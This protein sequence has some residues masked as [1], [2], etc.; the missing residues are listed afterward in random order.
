[1]TTSTVSLNKQRCLR[2]K[3]RRSQ[4]IW[5][6]APELSPDLNSNKVNDRRI[7]ILDVAPDQHQPF[8]SAARIIEQLIRLAPLSYKKQLAEVRSAMNVLVASHLRTSNIAQLAALRRVS[9]ESI[10]TALIIDKVTREINEVLRVI[11]GGRTIVVPAADRLDRSTL[12]ILARSM[13]LLQE[14]DPLTWEWRLKSVPEEFSRVDN[15]HAPQ[16]LWTATRT[17]FMTKLQALLDPQIQTIGSGSVDYDHEQMKSSHHSLADISA[18]LVLQ[19]YDSCFLWASQHPDIETVSG[20]SVDLWRAVAIAAVNTGH[21]RSALEFL[22]RAYL[23]A[24]TATLRAHTSYL[25]GLIVA[26][27]VYSI[28]ESNKLYERGIRELESITHDD[29][30]DPELEE[31]WILNGFALNN[32]LSVRLKGHD[33]A[34]VSK[35]TFSLLQQAFDL[36]R[37]GGSPGRVYLRFNLLR[38]MSHFLEIQQHYDFALKTWQ[39]TFKDLIEEVSGHEHVGRATINYRLG[40]LHY[41]A[42]RF[43]EAARFLNT[44]LESIK[45]VG[46][47]FRTLHI[48]RA[49][50]TVALARKQFDEASEAFTRGIKLGL[51]HRILL[52]SRYHLQSLALTHVS[53]GCKAK[54]YEVLDWMR[55][56]EPEIFE[57]KEVEQKTTL[58]LWKLPKLNSSLPNSVPEIDLEDT[59]FLP[60]GKVL[61]GVVSV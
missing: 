1:M 35:K 44:A 37:E 49:I 7:L 18:A 41:K 48:L 42:N 9:R 15:T 51:K 33:V 55:A 25:Q 20:D 47:D 12:K 56:E 19:N 43:S 6:I 13:L 31:A 38:N 3:L 54:A 24:P 11:A 17:N 23:E 8:A 46:C 58:G 34:I 40:Y 29:P 16:G 10:D 36:V 50:G 60:V 5:S 59:P 21:Y 4:R 2:P 39:E 32:L 61:T 57:D 53:A 22:E 30:G 26:K 52:D 14:S 28:E 45:V 27:R